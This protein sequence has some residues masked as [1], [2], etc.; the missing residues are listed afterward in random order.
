MQCSVIRYLAKLGEKERLENRF[1]SEITRSS[2]LLKHGPPTSEDEEHEKHR[3]E[4][5]NNSNK[6][7]DKNLLEVNLLVATIIASIT[8]AAAVSMPGGYGNPDG[9]QNLRKKLKFKY[10][11]AFDSVAFGLAAASMII[12]FLFVSI[13]KLLGRTL[14]YPFKTIMV[15]T[16]SSIGCTVCAFIAAIQASLELEQ[17]DKPTSES[18]QAIYAALSFIIPVFIYAIS[19]VVRCHRHGYYVMCTRMYIKASL[20]RTIRSIICSQGR[21]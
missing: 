16:Y 17:T 21:P 12:H 6:S 8:F 18:L 5:S 7:W 9:L 1:D 20:A 3:K 13:S 11:L 10:F 19:V 15:L 2:L 14:S 4:D